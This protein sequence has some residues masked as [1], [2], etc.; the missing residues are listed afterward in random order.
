MSTVAILS[1]R[2]YGQDGVSVEARKWEWAYRSL[3][4]EIA[5]IAGELGAT[6][7]PHVVIPEL[8][9]THP[10]IVSLNERAFGPPLPAS[11]R[12][13]L[14]G[15]I[16]ALADTIE[17]TLQAALARFGVDV[18]SVENALA[19]PMNLPLGLA[20][21]RLIAGGQRTIARHHDFYWERERFHHNN[22]EWLLHAAFPPSQGP[23][24]H[25][26]INDQARRQLRRK[27]GLNAIWVPNAFDFSHT[28]CVDDYNGELRKDLGISSEQKIF[29]QPTRFIPRKGIHRAV[30]LVARLRADYGLDGVLVVSGPAGDEGYEYEQKVLAEAAQAGVKVICAAEG[31]GFVR[32]A[33]G[34]R[35]RYT[36]GDAYV[37]AD[38]VTFPSDLEG[39]GNPVIEAAMYGR[40]LFVNRYPVLDD[41]LMLAEDRFDFIV[42]DGDV[43]TAAVACTYKVLTDPVAREEMVYGNFVTA[44]RHFLMER[45]VQRLQD[46]LDSLRQAQPSHSATEIEDIRVR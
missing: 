22:V 41:I 43:T 5:L 19:I 25:V 27:R 28:E 46:L 11:E 7:T 42:I 12:K 29:L 38:L 18:L 33:S 9:F 44:R 36:M 6:D 40:P 15:E 39:F 14:R 1:T 13:A 10:R 20:L 21:Q 2:L 31:V 45:L 16:E 17:R 32:S 4:C 34:G 23:I 8:A 3:G 35:K 37:Y 26:T 30:E 24:R